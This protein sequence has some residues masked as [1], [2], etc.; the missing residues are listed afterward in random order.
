MLDGHFT[1]PA[2]VYGCLGA[3]ASSPLLKQARRLRSQ[4]TGGAFTKQT[5]SRQSRDATERGRDIYDECGAF[6]RSAL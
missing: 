4:G 2:P 1:S 5:S 3:R 6:C